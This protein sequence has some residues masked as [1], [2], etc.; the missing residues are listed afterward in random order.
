MPYVPGGGAQKDSGLNAVGDVYHATNVYANNVL[1]ALWQTPGESASFAGV[2]VSVS[3]ELPEAVQGSINTQ[4]SSYIANPDAS[5]NA[6]AAEGGVKPNY[7][8]TPNDESTGTGIISETTSSSDVCSF[9]T[10]TLD[11]ASRGMWRESGQGGKPSNPNIT[12]IWKSLGYP[13]SGAWTTDQTAW[14]MG[15]VNFAL[16][17]SGYK[18]VQT[19]WAYDIRDKTSK[20][21]ATKI[22]NEQAQCGDIALWSYGHVNFVYQKKGAGFSMCGGNQSPKNAGN[23]PNDG[24]VTV[25]WPSGCAPSNPTW[26]G[27]FRPSRT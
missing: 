9:L 1:V 8:G 16:K 22:P 15:F 5:Y 21:N 2:S 11:E 7:P 14:C 18:Y 27:T 19:A 26:V 24:D 20:W 25:S 6:V 4:T 13:A 10:K 12:G 3:V 23:N 17:S